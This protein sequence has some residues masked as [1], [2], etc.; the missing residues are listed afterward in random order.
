[1]SV[2]NL[3]AKVFPIGGYS[4]VGQYNDQQINQWI[5]ELDQLPVFTFKSFYSFR[6]SIFR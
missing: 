4:S 1:M 6:G 5:L 2:S 3:D